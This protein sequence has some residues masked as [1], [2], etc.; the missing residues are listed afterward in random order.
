ML[1]VDLLRVPVFALSMMTSISSFAAQTMACV[2]LPFYFERT[3]GYSDVATGLLM[4]PWPLATALVAPFAGRWSDRIAAERLA[5]IGMVVMAVGLASLALLGAAPSAFDLGWRLAVCG[6]GFGLFQSPNNRVIVGSAP[7]ERSGGA[8]GLQSMALA[9][10]LV[11]GRQ[12]MWI[13]CAAA[14]LALFAAAA[15]GLRRTR[16]LAV[17]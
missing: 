15:G 14:L 5:S 6:L 8:S 9:F 17:A 4:T 1:P 3:L 16:V 11:P 10:A 12:T 7:R 13:T 2:A